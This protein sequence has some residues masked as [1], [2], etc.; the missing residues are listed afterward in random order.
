M[1]AAVAAVTEQ[2]AATE[3]IVISEEA[4]EEA[5]VTEHLVETTITVQAVLAAADMDSPE[6]AEM[7]ETAMAQ[8]AEAVTVQAVM[9]DR[10]AASQ[11][12]EA[13]VQ[14]MPKVAELAVLAS[15]LFNTSSTRHN[16]KENTK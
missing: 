16:R 12:A 4:A 3:D 10:Q 11:Q 14:E 13:A 8:A 6:R 5:A 9:L 1:A 7:P 2:K 15:P